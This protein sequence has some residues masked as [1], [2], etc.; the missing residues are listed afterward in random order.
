MSELYTPY[1]DHPYTDKENNVTE[2]SAENVNLLNRYVDIADNGKMSLKNLDAGDDTGTILYAAF[3]FKPRQE[4][5]PF[6][7]YDKHGNVLYRGGRQEFLAVLTEIQ[8]LKDAAGNIDK[9]PEKI[10]E[11]SAKAA[12]HVPFSTETRLEEMK[13]RLDLISA[14][15][16]PGTAMPKESEKKIDDIMV[17]AANTSNIMAV[18]LMDKATRGEL[19]D[20]ARGTEG[21][22][23]EKAAERMLENQSSCYKLTLLGDGT[24]PT[25]LFVEVTLSDGNKY[26]PGQSAKELNQIADKILDYVNIHQNAQLAAAALAIALSGEENFVRLKPEQLG[27]IASNKNLAAM[28][29]QTT[30]QNVIEFGRNGRALLG[31]QISNNEFLVKAG[32]CIG[33]DTVAAIR[34]G[35]K[36]NLRHNNEMT[37]LMNTILAQVRAEQ[38]QMSHDIPAANATPAAPAAKV[39]TALERKETIPSKDLVAEFQKRLEELHKRKNPYGLELDLQEAVRIEKMPGANTIKPV[40]FVKKAKEEPALERSLSKKPYPSS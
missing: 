7:S 40:K 13:Q 15:I 27:E 28:I 4:L 34:N 3:G 29:E 12:A 16:C 20:L 18:D 38:H 24:V 9:Q 10:A 2:H 36:E 26:P 23:L 17:T 5:T 1:E 6:P 39:R 30:E 25:S 21:L 14:I 8:E 37:G 22:T 35:I 33:H 11:I 19:P 32:D 31:K